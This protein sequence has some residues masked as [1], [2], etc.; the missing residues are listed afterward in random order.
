MTISRETVKNLLVNIV[1]FLLIFNIISFAFFLWVG[2]IYIT[3]WLFIVPFLLMQFLRARTIK[4]R[5]FVFL[6]VLLAAGTVYI[7]GDLTSMWFIAIFMGLACIYSFYVRVNS[8]WELGRFTAVFMLFVHIVMFVWAEMV[9]NDPT[10]IHQQLTGTALVI[11]GF[12][13]VYVHMDN[14]DIKVNILQKSDANKHSVGGILANNNILIA[15]FTSLTVIAGFLI[16]FV[17]LGRI[18]SGAFRVVSGFVVGLL[19]GLGEFD[20]MPEHEYI[21]R[22]DLFGAEETLMIDMNEIDDEWVEEIGELAF[23]IE[24]WIVWVVMS[25]AGAA[26][27]IY[28]IYLFIRSYK[29]QLRK[30]R[31]AERDGEESFQLGRNILSDLRDLLPRFGSRSKNA[32]RRAYAKKVNRHIRLGADVKKADTTDVIADKIRSL[33][34]IDELTLM[35]EK[36][37]YGG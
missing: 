18:V 2:E 22:S 21:V 26:F 25:I 30:A 13:L 36:V 1:V 34:D 4:I 7:F 23:W 10:A 5:V 24:R 19:P 15:I 27:V 35:Y 8:E 37:R 33:E 11:V 29:D 31:N 20:Y 16:T 32:I 6:H 14:V 3:W 17:P 9:A 28:F 12:I